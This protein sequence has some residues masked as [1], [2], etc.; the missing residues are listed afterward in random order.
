[1]LLPVS[2]IILNRQADYDASLEV[3]SKP[4]LDRTEFNLNEIGQMTVTNQTID[5]FRYIDCTPMAEALYSFA[6]ETIK[7]IIRIPSS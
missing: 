4:L 6:A 7:K 3:L 2:A 1:V 5:F